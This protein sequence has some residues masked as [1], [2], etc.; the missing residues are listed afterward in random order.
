M[1]KYSNQDRSMLTGFRA[2]ELI[3]TRKTSKKDKNILWERNAQ[4]SYHE[5]KN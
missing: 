3:F 1:H 2:A 5:I 4:K